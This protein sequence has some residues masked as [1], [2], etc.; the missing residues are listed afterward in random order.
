MYCIKS[1]MTYM[2]TVKF[3]LILKTLL[4]SS[5]QYV[6]HN[7]LHAKLKYYFITI[8][9]KVIEKMVVVSSK[10]SSVYFS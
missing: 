5:E 4:H 1:S 10:L 3:S 9:K 6:D 7:T 8:K 2:D